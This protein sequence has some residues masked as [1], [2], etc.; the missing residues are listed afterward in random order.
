MNNK[1]PTHEQR[2]LFLSHC[3]GN[4]F[5]I[6]STCVLGTVLMW[7]SELGQGDKKKE[8]TKYQVVI[9]CMCAS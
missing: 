5:I 6:V 7:C 2:V 8:V 4:W 3:S 9:Y 1:E